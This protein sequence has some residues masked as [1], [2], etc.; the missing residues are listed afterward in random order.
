MNMRVM[1]VE[2]TITALTME[3]TVT[4]LKLES[5]VTALKMESTIAVGVMKKQNFQ[6]NNSF[7]FFI[8]LCVTMS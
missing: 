8:K 5:T 2:S 4:A 6:V 3:S 7:Q 1:R